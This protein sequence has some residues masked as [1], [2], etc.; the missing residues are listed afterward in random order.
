MTRLGHGSWFM[1]TFTVTR[2]TSL[3]SLH[4]RAQHVESVS[5]SPVLSKR[6]SPFQWLGPARYIGMSV[7]QLVSFLILRPISSPDPPCKIEEVPAVDAI[8]L[9]V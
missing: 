9:S 1:A 8:V 6:C 7:A 5:Y 3:S 4:P 2:A